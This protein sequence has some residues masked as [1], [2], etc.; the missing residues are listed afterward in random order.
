MHFLHTLLLFILAS[1]SYQNM[2]EMWAERAI[3]QVQLEHHLGAQL[4]C[5]TLAIFGPRFLSQGF[6]WYK[7]HSW[8]LWY[9]TKMIEGSLKQ[10]SHRRGN[11]KL[12]LLF[13]GG[14]VAP[15]GSLC[16]WNLLGH[17]QWMSLQRRRSVYAVG[18]VGHWLFSQSCSLTGSNIMQNWIA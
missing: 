16:W 8:V 6:C 15:Q 9:L 4:V 13:W 17:L 10:F 18:A 12:M 3:F 5:L 14:G 11:W 7:A 2:V 1:C